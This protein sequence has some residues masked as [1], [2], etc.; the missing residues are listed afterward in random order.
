MMMCLFLVYACCRDRTDLESEIE[1]LTDTWGP[2]SRVGASADKW[3]VIDEIGEM[4]NA[5]EKVRLAGKAMDKFLAMHKKCVI[6]CDSESVYLARECFIRS[7][8]DILI[9][10]KERCPDVVIAG[11]RMVSKWLDAVEE[12]IDYG[13]DG[14]PLSKEQTDLVGYSE[15]QYFLYF[16]YTFATAIYGSLMNMPEKKRGSMVDLIRTLFIN[17]RGIEYVKKEDME[18]LMKF[19]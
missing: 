10:D 12:I 13:S 8:Y 4:T 2:G 11:W 14:K 9:R 16:R 18:L 7:C 1:E 3:L 5:A 15:R 19:L 6:H 17:R